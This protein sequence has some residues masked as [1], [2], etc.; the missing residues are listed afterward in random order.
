MA[1]VMELCRFG[2]LFEV[3]KAAHDVA[4]LPPDIRSG[5]THPR[6]RE[7]LKL[8]VRSNP[9]AIACCSLRPMAAN[10][11]FKTWIVEW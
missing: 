1:I 5:S 6:T 2:S 4:Q 3:I 11:G 8:K 10:Q 9:S 7:E